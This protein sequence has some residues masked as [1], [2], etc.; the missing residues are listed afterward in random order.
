VNDLYLIPKAGV[1]V[2]DP[3]NGKPLADA[4]ETKPRTSYWLRRLRDGD[5]V[6]GKAPKAAAT[7]TASNKGDAK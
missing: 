5:V 7:A 6:E 2:R 1:T 4:G 3:L